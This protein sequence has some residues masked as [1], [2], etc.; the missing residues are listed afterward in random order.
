LLVQVLT[1]L[2][3]SDSEFEVLRAAL[4]ESHSSPPVTST[5]DT[6][7]ALPSQPTTSRL[8]RFSILSTPPLQPAEPLSTIASIGATSKKGQSHWIF[9]KIL[10]KIHSNSTITLA[11]TPTSI[12]TTKDKVIY[13]QN[14]LA[15]P[16]TYKKAVKDIEHIQRYSL[17]ASFYNR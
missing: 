4:R 14:K 3:V 11:S 5:S 15:C 13:K 6:T 2:L 10:T 7:S 9:L 8:A 16:A 1:L 17:N 12:T